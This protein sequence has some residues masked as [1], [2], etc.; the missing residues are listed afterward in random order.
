ME[1]IKTLKNRLSK[2]G[3]ETTYFSNIPYIY[4]D[5]V[6]GKRIKEKFYSEHYFTIG[7]LG[8]RAGSGFDFIDLKEMFKIIR[9]YAK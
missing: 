6:N 5:T 7:F 1:K 3:I 4:L 9:K 8:V 2:I